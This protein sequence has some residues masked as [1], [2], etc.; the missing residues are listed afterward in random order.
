M[1]S[2]YSWEAEAVSTL[3]CAEPASEGVKHAHDLASALLAGGSAALCVK[4]VRAVH[5]CLRS[6]PPVSMWPWFA[7]RVCLDHRKRDLSTSEM[8]SALKVWSQG[9]V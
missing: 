3:W 4:E 2:F 5:P 8:L 1:P 6:M 7:P 9:E